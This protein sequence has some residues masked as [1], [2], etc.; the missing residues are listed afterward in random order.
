M[1][2]LFDK[3]SSRIVTKLL[4]YYLTMLALNSCVKQL[5]VSEY[6]GANI[7]D[8]ECT[9]QGNVQY[10]SGNSYNGQIYKNQIDGIGEYTWKDKTKYSGQ[11]KKNKITGFGVYRW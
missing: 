6:D 1:R 10:Y 8:E 11:F 7:S 3:G 5:I 4:N 2:H 9:G